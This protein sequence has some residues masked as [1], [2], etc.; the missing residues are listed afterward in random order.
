MYIIQN[1]YFEKHFSMECSRVTN[2]FQP[3]KELEKIALTDVSLLLNPPTKSSIACLDSVLTSKSPSEIWALTLIQLT[4]L[5]RR[6][7]N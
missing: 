2:V 5:W 1:T 4:A 3:I 7:K 6:I